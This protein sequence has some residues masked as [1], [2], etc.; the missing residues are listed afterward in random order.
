[1]NAASAPNSVHGQAA[2]RL[3]GL[4]KVYSDLVA[5]DDLSLEVAEGEILTFLGPS[6]FRRRIHRPANLLDVKVIG[7]HAGAV[8]AAVNEDWGLHAAGDMPANNLVVVFRRRD[9]T[10]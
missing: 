7:T 3:E 9:G 5:V 1:M 4:H 6:G 8:S 2:I 10:E